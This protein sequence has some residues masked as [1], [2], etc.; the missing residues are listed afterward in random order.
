MKYLLSLL[1]SLSLVALAGC[2]TLNVTP[3]ETNG[4]ETKSVSVESVSSTE[5]LNESGDS[6]P[7]EES[8]QPADSSQSQTTNSD[9]DD[10][11]IAEIDESMK[12]DMESFFTELEGHWNR[13]GTGEFLLISRGE[14]S[15]LTF[16][17]AVYES[18][19]FVPYT[20]VELGLVDG[21][22]YE[23]QLYM[24]RTDMGEL[25]GII[26][27]HE[28]AITITYSSD[29]PNVLIVDGIE[30]Y[31]AGKDFDEAFDKYYADVV[32]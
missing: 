23:L 5:E 30:Y 2:I 9:P 28:L 29:D 22:T 7:A 14:N 26:E 13:A 1:L 11:D 17:P 4:S 27:E 16:L 15:E 19:G 6:Q 10:S 32:G 21:D 25:G 3:T 20:W 24:P 18:G 8:S 31:F 12:Y